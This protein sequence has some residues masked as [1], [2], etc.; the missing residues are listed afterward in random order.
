VS[1]A[2]E[3]FDLARDFG[4]A[5]GR[6]SSVLYD[7]FTESG[8]AFAEDWASN[9]AATSGEH[10]KHYPASISSETRISIGIHVETGPDSSMP[11]GSMGR[12]F[13]LGSQ[14]QPPHLDGLRAL[15]AAEKRLDRGADTAIGFLLP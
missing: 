5:S 12:G 6:V 11:Q 10:G 9:A 14:N 1:G 13:E 15:P 3:F 8:E 2:D 4:K 7:V